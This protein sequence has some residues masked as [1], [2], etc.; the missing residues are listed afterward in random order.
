ML[1]PQQVQDIRSKAN[2][3]SPSATSANGSSGDLYSN[4]DNMTPDQR[5]QGLNARLTSR[6][7]TNPPPANTTKPGGSIFDAQ[8]Y[9]KATEGGI[10]GIWNDVKHT[11]L[12]DLPSILGHGA[13]GGLKAA[14]QIPVNVARGAGRIVKGIATQPF[15]TL[16]DVGNIVGG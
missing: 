10:S 14:G 7:M 8:D 5:I 11:K 4:W 12:S 2:I 3:V 6:S 15:N 9:S 1:T 13:L 16:K